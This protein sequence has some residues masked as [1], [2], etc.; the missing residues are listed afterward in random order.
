MLCVDYVYRE[1][2][3]TESLHFVFDGGT[4]RDTDIQQIVLPASELSEYRFVPL[5]EAT[6][7]LHWRIAKRLVHCLPAR[8]G[9]KAIYLENSQP[10]WQ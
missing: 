1:Q 9:D 4:L 3:K 6:V 2:H 7:M 8:G 5:E 10:V